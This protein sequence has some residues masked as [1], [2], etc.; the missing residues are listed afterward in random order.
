MLAQGRTGTQSIKLIPASRVYVKIPDST[1]AAPYNTYASYTNGA[2]PSGWTDLGTIGGTAK[3]I[4]EHKAKEVRT[5][6]DSYLRAAYLDQKSARVEFTLSQ[7]DDIVIET[8]TDAAPNTFVAGA[9]EYL[10]GTTD[11][12]ELALL[13]VTQNKLDGKE[14]HFYNPRTLIS[15]NFDATTEELGLKCVALAPFFTPV[16]S[17][18]ESAFSLTFLKPTFAGYVSRFFSQWFTSQVAI[19]I[20]HN[21]NSVNIVP[22][23][24][25][26]YGQSLGYGDFSVVDLNHVLLTFAVPMTGNVILTMYD[27]S[28]SVSTSF[29]NQTSLTVQHNLGAS[30]VQ[31]V[32]YDSNNTIFQYSDFQVNNPNSATVSFSVP[33][34]GRVLIFIPVGL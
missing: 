10:L 15:F 7:F 25:D 24:T 20:Q 5:G 21:L 16:G 17:A 9:A 14:V 29:T 13:L 34:S 1:Y 31:A 11:L 2:T 22:T 12:T 8:I 3:V 19:P 33:V 4:Y 32:V 26:P 30:N 27:A 23:V 18:V 6:I 28:N